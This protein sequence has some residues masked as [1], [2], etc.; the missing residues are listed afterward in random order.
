MI[1]RI[2]LSVSAVLI[3]IASFAAGIFTADPLRVWWEDQRLGRL[4][5]SDSRYLLM[6]E[7]EAKHP[8]V[9]VINVG[10]REESRVTSYLSIHILPDQAFF[11]TLEK[12]EG[13]ERMLEIIHDAVASA[14]YYYPNVTYIGVFFCHSSAVPTIEGKQYV[15]SVDWGVYGQLDAFIKWLEMPTM[16]ALQTALSD[17]SLGM[18]VAGVTGYPLYLDEYLRRPS[19]IQVPWGSGCPTCQR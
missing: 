9:L 10:Y 11:A 17:G 1:K 7:I 16:D 15:V 6:A 5:Q 2:L 4:M 19:F 14:L 12:E 8:E 13:M 3:V 18:Y